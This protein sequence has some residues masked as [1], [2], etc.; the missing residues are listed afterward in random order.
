MP[1]KALSLNRTR[2][3]RILFRPADRYSNKGPI[4]SRRP[5]RPSS[6]FACKTAVDHTFRFYLARALERAEIGEEYLK[7]IGSLRE[8]LELH[9]S[10]WPE[11]PGNTRSDPHAWSKPPIC[12]LLTLVVRIDPASPRFKTMRVA[13][14]LI[15]LPSLQETYP[16]PGGNGFRGV[17]T[18]RQGT[19]GDH[20]AVRKFEQQLRGWR[21]E[22]AVASGRKPYRKE[23]ART[24]A[25]Q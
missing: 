12:D 19:G 7:S 14:H 4:H 6:C 20:K 8:L 3:Q 21:M 13:Q 22:L 18:E 25:R 16:T 17:R 1:A 23:G 10:A 11:T 5:L 24:Q 2:A 15:S 9:F